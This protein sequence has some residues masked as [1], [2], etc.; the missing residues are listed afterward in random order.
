MLQQK[1]QDLE[2]VPGQ[3]YLLSVGCQGPVGHVQHRAAAGE[4]VGGTGEVIGSP[5]HGLHLGGEHLQVK[6]LGQQVIPAHLHGH[7][8]VHVV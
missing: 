6:G 5:Q 3:L 2:L 8:Q 4:Q 1:L 7:H